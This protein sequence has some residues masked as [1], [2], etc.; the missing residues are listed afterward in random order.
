M[1]RKVTLSKDALLWEEGDMARNI[2]IVESGK[3][4]VRVGGQ[5]VGMVW[6][7]MVIGESAILNEEGGKAAERRTASVVAWEEPTVVSEYPAALV[8]RTF[9]EGRMTVTNAILASLVGQICRN[10]L[11]IIAEHQTR[12]MIRIPFKGLMDGLLQSFREEAALIGKWDEFTAAF[13]VLYSL[14]DTT[15]SL[16]DQLVLS[17]DPESITRA[18]DFFRDVYKGAT[19]A[20]VEVEDY[21]R[22]EREKHSW[23]S[24]LKT[25]AG[26]R[27]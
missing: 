2:A 13:H 22:A 3:L 10:C 5:L 19:A 7:R 4:A 25:D 23:L 18:S 9:E 17:R 11:M 24:S 12:P 26:A 1:T 15:E 16:R 6:P 14:R 20:Q 21:L 8:R 27:L